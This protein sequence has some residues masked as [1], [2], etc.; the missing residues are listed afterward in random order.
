MVKNKMSHLRKKYRVWFNDKNERYMDTYRDVK[1]KSPKE[2]IEKIKKKNST[3]FH[4]LDKKIV[5][6]K[7]VEYLKED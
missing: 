5:I 3:Y 1:A 7:N 4:P 6:I 2:A